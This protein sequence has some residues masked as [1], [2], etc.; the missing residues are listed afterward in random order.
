MAQMIGKGI[1][2][3]VSMISNR[4]SEVN[5][6][7]MGTDYNPSNPSK[8]IQYLDANNLYGWEMSQPLP[9]GG[10]EWMTLDEQK[11]CILEVDLDYPHE[12]HNLHDDYPLA[13]ERLIVNKVE[14]LIPNLSDKKKYVIHHRVLKQYLKLGLRLTKIQRGIKFEESPFMKKYIDL[15]TKLRTASKLEFEKDFFKLMNNSVFGKIMENIRNQVDVQ[16]VNSESKA[17]K[18]AAKP[19][20]D[21]LT[22]FD[23]NLVAVHMKKIKLYFNMPIYLGMSILD[24]SKTL[25]YDF[26]YEYMK[27]KYG[28]RAKL[29]LTDADSLVY[30]IQLR[31]FTKTFLRTLKKL[32]DTSNYPANHSSKIPTGENKKVLVRR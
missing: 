11:P 26:H 29:L 6:K 32:F 10:F 21:H 30:E 28:D 23:E 1:R 27:P 5:N 25:M 13:P 3:G 14:K 20:Y 24:I 19:N 22:I 8:Y 17:V 7:Y 16:L 31:I 4:H 12:L 9:T 15:N 18:L 2:G